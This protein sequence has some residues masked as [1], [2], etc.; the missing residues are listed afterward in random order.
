MQTL[1]QVLNLLTSQLLENLVQR[2]LTGFLES[3]LC[4]FDNVVSIANDSYLYLKE[5]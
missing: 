1:R 2:L 5:E 3:Q 4:A